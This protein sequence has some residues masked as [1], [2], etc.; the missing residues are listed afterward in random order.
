MVGSINTNRWRGPSSFLRYGLAVLAVPGATIIQHFGDMHFAVTPAY[1][2][3]VLLT[4]W[5]GGL[6]PGL[7]AIALS[8][9][10]LMYYFVPP[11]RTLVIDAAYIPSLILFSLAA[12]FVTW[13]SVRERSATKSLVYA[14]DQLALKICEL[15]KSNEALQAE[16]AAHAHAERELGRLRSDLA[17]VSRVMTLGELAASIAHEVT[18]PIASARNNACSALNFL[19]R[20]PTNLG[21]VREALKCA[22][23][24]TDRAGHIVHTIRDH[25]KKAPARKDRFDLNEAINEV[26]LLARS[27]MTENQV[28][29]QTQLAEGSLPIQGNR[30]QLQQVFFNLIMNAVE[31]MAASETRQLVVCSRTAGTQNVLVSVFDSGS[32]LEAEKVS[33]LFEAFYTTKPNGM[34]MGLA[35]SRS[36]IQAH[37][38]RLTVRANEPRGAIF[39]VELPN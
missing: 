8:N 25:H 26:L 1:F 34:G 15:E 31:A 23:A 20:Q 35:M 11:T 36:I 3:A 19:D 29:A 27:A 16:I 28:S 22:V 6:G 10:A 12:L 9:L 17:H 39:E 32:G 37:G 21:E 38:G 30:V 18:Q 24:D 5:F 2:C 33:R 7:L 13:L 4:A 14:R